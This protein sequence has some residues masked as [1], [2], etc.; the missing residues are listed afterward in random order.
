MVKQFEYN[1]KAN[2]RNTGQQQ[3]GLVAQ[4]LEKVAPEL[5]STFTHQEEDADTKVAKSEDYLMISESSIKYMLVNAVKEQHN[6]IED[7]REEVA[8]L[9]E[10]VNALLNENTDINHQNIQL[11]ERDIYL[12][13]N[14]P[15]PFNDNT[16]I[17]Y[18]T[19]VDAKN[20]VLNVFDMNGQL[21]HSEIITHMGIGEVQLKAGTIAAG[22]YSYSLVID[23]NIVDTKRMVITK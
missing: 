4:D 12:Q 5:V 21:I 23:G 2:L 3:I 20:A 18:S 8:D 11:N 15:N 6:E 7:L 14:Q 10:M 13:Q 16:L 19:P 9:K 22:T 17:K 1:G